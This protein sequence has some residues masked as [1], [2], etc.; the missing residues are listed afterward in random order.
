MNC[1]VGKTEQVVRISAGAAIL[2]AGLAYRSWWGLLG[3]APIITGSMRYCPV[4]QVLGIG[5]CKRVS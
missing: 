1:N 2:L 4:N 5:N 3:L